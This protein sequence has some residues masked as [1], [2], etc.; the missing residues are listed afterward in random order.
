MQTQKIDE[1]YLDEEDEDRGPVVAHLTLHSTN[2]VHNLYRGSNQIGR[3]TQNDV[4]VEDATVSDVHAEIE[5]RENNEAH[6]KDL[7]SS[8]GTIVETEASSNDYTHVLKGQTLLLKEGCYV[9]F[10]KCVKEWVSRCA[11][12]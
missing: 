1:Y 9:R 4:V 11:I 8:N 2:T 6:V 7:R 10:G 12:E 3:G 5:I